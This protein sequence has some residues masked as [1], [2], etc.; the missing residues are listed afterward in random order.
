MRYRHYRRNAAR[1]A[2]ANK[3]ATGAAV[4]WEPCPP[5]DLLVTA[6]V[7]L[8]PPLEPL[9]LPLPLPPLLMAL[10][11]NVVAPVVISV[12]RVPLVLVVTR[13]DVTVVGVA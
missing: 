7:V 1:P 9:P 13:A 10:V 3:P 12:V 6:V 4:F 8:E 11:V 2:A 5:L